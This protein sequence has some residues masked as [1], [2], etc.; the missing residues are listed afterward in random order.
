[1]FRREQ[2]YDGDSRSTREELAKVESELVVLKRI[3]E[4]KLHAN[5]VKKIHSLGYQTGHMHPRGTSHFEF[6]TA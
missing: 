2:K 5:T 6:V 4:I 1:M 3:R